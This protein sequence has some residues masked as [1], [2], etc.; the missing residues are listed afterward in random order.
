[1]LFRSAAAKTIG[2]VLYDDINYEREF[3]MIGKD[4]SATVARP[5]SVSD[6]PL[7][8]WKE[9]K[10]DGL[11]VGSVEK[12]GSGILVRM[13]LIKVAT[14]EPALGKE[15]SGSIANPRQ[16]AHTIS[17][18][19]H[20]AGVDVNQLAD[21]AIRLRPVQLVAPGLLHPRQFLHYHSFT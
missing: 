7:E 15:Y 20:M 8:G 21:V 10:A 13:R 2:D 9:L 3:Y 12:T 16:Y 11:I 4:M 18:E 17:D 19:I 1:M 14:G 6:V 5:R